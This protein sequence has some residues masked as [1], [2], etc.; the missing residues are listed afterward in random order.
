M[1][2][3]K[4]MRQQAR[5]KVKQQGCA[6]LVSVGGCVRAPTRPAWLARTGQQGQDSVPQHKKYAA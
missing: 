3:I 1:V 2:C 5:I 4:L 6:D